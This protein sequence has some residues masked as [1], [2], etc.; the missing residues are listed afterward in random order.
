MPDI[1]ETSITRF[2]GNRETTVERVSTR[3]S[4]VNKTEGNTFVSTSE[5]GY[6]NKIRKLAVSNPDK[7]IIISDTGDYVYAKMPW[8]WFPNVRPKSTRNMSDEQ[9]AAQAERMRAARMNKKN[10][11]NCKDDENE[12]EEDN[13]ENGEDDEDDEDDDAEED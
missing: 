6:M 9:K 12:E 1:S 5:R 4:Q 10:S 2:K 11:K 8:E 7:V 3:L 13:A